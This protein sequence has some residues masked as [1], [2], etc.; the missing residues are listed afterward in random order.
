MAKGYHY[1]QVS[2]DGMREVLMTSSRNSAVGATLVSPCL[3]SSHGDV[4]PAGLLSSM[5][6]MG[7]VL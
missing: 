6:E 4:D 5:R 2:E 3:S 1:D 7:S